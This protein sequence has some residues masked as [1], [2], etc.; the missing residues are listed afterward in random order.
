MHEAGDDTAATNAEATGGVTWMTYREIAAAR[1]ITHAAAIRLVQR[2]RWQKRDGSNDGLAHVLVPHDAVQPTPPVRRPPVMPIQRPLSSGPTTP[3][4]TA[5]FET[6]LAAIREAHA[7]E[8]AAL[9]DQVTAAISRADQAEAGR[10]AERERAD[11]AERG[12]DAERVRADALRDRVDA[13]QAT[14]ETTET[15]AAVLRGRL[16]AMQAQLAEAHVTLQAAT[17]TGRRADRAEA[18][19]HEAEQ[20]RDMANARADELSGRLDT[21]QHLAREAAA[22]AEAAQLAQAEAEADAAELRQEDAARKGRG[23]LARL[24]AAWRGE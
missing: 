5:A 13:L 7:G 3:P 21:A 6:A 19:A 4:D 8:T 17:E 20:G 1:G 9:R 10:E 22:A 18:R 23:R 15:R 11:R 24:R 2:H 12:R 14:A 16:D